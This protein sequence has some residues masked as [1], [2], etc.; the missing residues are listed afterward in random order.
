MITTNDDKHAHR[1]RREKRMQRGLDRPKR[2]EAISSR[3]P[4]RKPFGDKK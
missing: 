1:A 2:K 4:K 3:F